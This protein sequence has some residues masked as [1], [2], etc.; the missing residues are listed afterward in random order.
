MENFISSLSVNDPLTTNPGPHQ[1]HD[2]SVEKQSQIR[3]CFTFS[4]PVPYRKT[5]SK[6]PI[7]FRVENEALLRPVCQNT[8]EMHLTY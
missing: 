8:A 7:L 5:L 4:Y 1:N 2:L 3:L 6:S